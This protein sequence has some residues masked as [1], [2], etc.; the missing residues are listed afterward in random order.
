MVK[1][2]FLNDSINSVCHERNGYFPPEFIQWGFCHVHLIDKYINELQIKVNKE[3]VLKV[4]KDPYIYH[5]IGYKYKPLNGIPNYYGTIYID[6]IMR[7]YE[8]IKKL[9]I[10]MKLLKNLKFI[11]NI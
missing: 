8:L 9:N 6:P 7:F 1:H 10:I 4:Y 5:L 2:N 11:K 3:E